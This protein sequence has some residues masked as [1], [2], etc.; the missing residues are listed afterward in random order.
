[1]KVRLLTTLPERHHATVKHYVGIPSQLADGK[2]TRS[3]MGP[4]RFLVIEERPDGVFLNRFD[5]TGECVGDT[6]HMSIDDAKNQADYEYR[7]DVL[8]WQDVPQAIED[9]AA[10]GMACA[11]QA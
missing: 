1:M 4:A 3:E 7:G 9:V 5:A 2:D 11:R 8:N 10:F 6:W